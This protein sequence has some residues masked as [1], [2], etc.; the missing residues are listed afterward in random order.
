V[1][2]AVA[3]LLLFVLLTACGSGS[4]APPRRSDAENRAAV[5]AVIAELERADSVQEVSG[6][7][8]TSLVQFGSIGM[9]ITV[10]DG[11]PVAEQEALMDRAEELVWRS[12]ADPI[13]RLGFLVVETST[14]STAPGRQ[15]SYDGRDEVG[16]LAEKYGPRPR[17]R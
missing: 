3:L 14:P 15:R 5:D 13:S 10:A 4:G 12:V 1:I 7:Y 9:T 2:R 16:R 11:T 8:E 6:A 17:P